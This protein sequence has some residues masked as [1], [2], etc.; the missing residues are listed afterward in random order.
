MTNFETQ[1]SPIVQYPYNKMNNLGN[2]QGGGE[3]R[4]VNFVLAKSVAFFFL[5]LEI[6]FAFGPCLSKAVATSRQH[7][8]MG[9][10]FVWVSVFTAA[11]RTT[12]AQY[13]G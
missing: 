8:V 2:C 5:N 12:G 1:L 3:V 13:S 6:P 9:S 4:C 10:M 11:S 7:G